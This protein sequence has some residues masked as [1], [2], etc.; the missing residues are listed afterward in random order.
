M[1][2]TTK[3]LRSV[4]PLLRASIMTTSS[5]SSS[6]SLHEIPIEIPLTDKRN[7]GLITLRNNLRCI[8]VSDVTSTKAAAALVVRAGASYDS[9][10]GLAHFTEHMLFLG[11]KKY[12]KENSYKEYL[13]KHG[14]SSNGA[15]AMEYTS[16]FFTVNADKFEGA[17]DI[18]AQFFK[19]PLFNDDAV[20]REVQAVDSEDSKNR[21]LDGR[22]VL[23]VFKSLLD[24]TH[25]YSKFST[26]NRA[27]L[28]QNNEVNN[29]LIEMHKFYKKHYRYSSCD[30][31]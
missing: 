2:L 17:L 19:E 31:I 13:S 15:T 20:F 11:S 14:G 7:Y 3:S 28:T 16:Y 8:V 10:P 22:R 18:F 29:T 9:L 27:T 24:E 6:S 4:R 23:Q 21:I 30:N 1:F 25:P 26:G 5:I 12:P